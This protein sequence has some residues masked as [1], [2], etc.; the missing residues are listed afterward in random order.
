MPRKKQ[1]VQK[2]KRN[3]EY[4]AG[5]HEAA[6]THIRRTGFFRF[7]GNYTLFA[8]IGA[9]VLGGGFLFTSFYQS[10]RSGQSDT[11]S[12]R[13]QGVTRETPEPDSTSTTGAQS[14]IKQ[15][16]APPTMSIDQAKT[17][18]ATFKT[19]NGEFTVELNAKEAPQTVNN[20]VFLAREGFYDGVTFFRVEPDFVVQT[21]DPTAT[22]LGGP[23]YD[24]PV[25]QTSLDF[26][27]GVLAMAKPPEAGAENNGSQFFITLVDSP[28]LNGKFTAF[29]RVV[30]GL[31]T[32]TALGAHQATD[33]EPGVRIQSVTIEES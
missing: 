31:D 32:L 14:T 10:T 6:A 7:F 13:G 22:G 27:A 8:I 29:G 11:G 2:Q 17:Y 23:G 24:L 16:G 25:E 20:F 30:D 9:L 3:K 1:V 21:G 18:V 19:E 12:V 4:R 5:A 15:Y 28:T 33:A 26:S